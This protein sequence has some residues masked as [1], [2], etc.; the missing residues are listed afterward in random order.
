[1]IIPKETDIRLRPPS[2]TD[3][4]RAVL[5]ERLRA[6][7][8]A[9]FTKA[10]PGL[11]RQGPPL[12]R[13]ARGADSREYSTAAGAVQGRQHLTTSRAPRGEDILQTKNEV[14]ELVLQLGRRDGE[15]AAPLLRLEAVAGGEDAVPR[16]A[17]APGVL[18]VMGPRPV[19]R[20]RST[21]SRSSKRPASRRHALEQ[22][23]AGDNFAGWWLDPKGKDFGANAKYF[24]HDI[25][26]AKK[27]LA[28]AGFA[29]GVDV[30]S[31]HITTAE[32]GADFPKQVEVLDGMA[33]RGRLR[34]EDD[35]VAFATEY[36]RVPRRQGQLRGH[37]ASACRQLSASW[38]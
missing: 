35:T 13:R 34:V 25:A 36:Q 1:M 4:L 31:C 6:F 33:L 30:E 38:T 17:R 10:Q 8:R 22:R 29:N 24:K 15:P 19:H 2:T 21:T 9:S 14:P 18:D 16:R 7:G 5:H 12:L 37:V 26:E 11:L 23:P 32:N 3:R 20:R 28:A 27:L